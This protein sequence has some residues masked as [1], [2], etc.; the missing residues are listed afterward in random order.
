[1][2]VMSI[3]MYD[4]NLFRLTRS[5]M[6]DGRNATMKPRWA[7]GTA[8][9]D[10]CRDGLEKPRWAREP[11]CAGEATIGDMETIKNEKILWTY[12]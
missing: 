4:M 5:P 2:M 10:G 8:I 11:R 6:C 9:G 12:L 1:M 7:M 3:M